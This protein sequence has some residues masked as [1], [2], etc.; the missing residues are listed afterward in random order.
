LSK[1]KDCSCILQYFKIS[2]S[3]WSISCAFL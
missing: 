2:S 3:N 1:K